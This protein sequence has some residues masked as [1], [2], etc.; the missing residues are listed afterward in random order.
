M[1]RRVLASALTRQRNCE[2]VDGRT[3][4]TSVRNEFVKLAS[5]PVL[6]PRSTPCGPSWSGEADFEWRMLQ[7]AVTRARRKPADPGVLHRRL[8]WIVE[9]CSSSPV[10]RWPV[11]S[12][13]RRLRALRRKARARGFGASGTAPL[14]ARGSLQGAGRPELPPHCGR[15][16]R[17]GANPWNDPGRQCRHG[18][19]RLVQALARPG[20]NA[21]G[22]R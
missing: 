15:R 7:D 5:R 14:R 16:A 10:S 3:G 12:P 2:L 1:S 21:A 13:C 4:S 11:L 18:A 22:G 8:A 20:S 6:R 9:V 17:M 19:L